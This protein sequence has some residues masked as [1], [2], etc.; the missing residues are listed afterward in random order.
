MFWRH[1]CVYGWPDCTVKYRS[2]V[3]EFLWPRAW[4]GL[5]L[6][7]A[8]TLAVAILQNSS[9]A[10]SSTLVTT[11]SNRKRTQTHAGSKSSPSLVGTHVE[12]HVYG[13]ALQRHFNQTL[14]IPFTGLDFPVKDSSFFLFC[15]ITLFRRFVQKKH[16]KNQPFVLSRRTSLFPSPRWMKHQPGFAPLRLWQ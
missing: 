7:F 11:R 6:C 10:S 5:T 2:L 3:P 16:H 8:P 4:I 1:S 12:W 15:F 14:K 13:A 9:S